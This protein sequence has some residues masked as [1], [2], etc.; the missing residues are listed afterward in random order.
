MGVAL[1]CTTHPPNPKKKK[2]KNEVEGINCVF[3]SSSS[4]S[5]LFF[6]LVG[7]PPLALPHHATRDAP[8]P[9]FLLTHHDVFLGRPPS[10]PL[11]SLLLVAS[12]LRTPLLPVLPPWRG[13]PLSPFPLPPSLAACRPPS[14]PSSCPCHPEGRVDRDARRAHPLGD[15]RSPQRLHNS[16]L[17]TGRSFLGHTPPHTTHT[18]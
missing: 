3:V 13:S 17:T 12:S 10:S 8:A 9:P 2:K 16:V 14:L 18:G 7:C 6:F 11:L 15:A 4:S 1:G 5:S